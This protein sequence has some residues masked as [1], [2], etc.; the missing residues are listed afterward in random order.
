MGGPAD[1]NG[2]EDSH[3]GGGSPMVEEAASY[4]R[5]SQLVDF[6]RRIEGWHGKIPEE[7]TDT[8]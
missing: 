1:G 5:L 4:Q 7:L 6:L 8:S 3:G 2:T